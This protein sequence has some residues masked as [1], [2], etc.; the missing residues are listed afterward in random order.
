MLRSNKWN[1]SVIGVLITGAV[2]VVL[3]LIFI[4][5]FFQ[6]VQPS[7]KGIVISWGQLQENV[8]DDGFYFKKPFW[9]DIVP[10][11]IGQNSTDDSK[12]VNAFRGIEPLSKDWQKMDIDAQIEYSITNPILFRRAT[13]MTEP[14]IIETLVLIPQVRRLLYDYTA[15]YTWKSLI[16]WGERQELG[17]RI[18]NTL[19]TGEVTKRICKDEK[20]TTD[21][22]TWIETIELA[23]CEI[24][25]NGKIEASTIKWVAI[26]S[27]NLRK[28]KPNDKIIQAVENAQ[29]KEQEVLVAKQEAQIETEKANKVIETKRGQT[30]SAKLQAEVDAYKIRVALE[31]KAEG[32]KAEALALIEQAKAQK[33]LKEALAGSKDLIEYKR[34]EVEMKLAEAQI[35]YAK[36]Y[37]GAVPNSISVIWTEEAKW[38]SIVMWA[39][40]VPTVSVK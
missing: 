13:W 15:E 4:S 2:L 31:E 11:F 5:E 22:T 23:G 10:V 21:E 27:V 16:Q 26:T 28:V 34:I 37:K 40:V 17:Q 12:N 7:Y 38:M 36:N 6:T 30:E 20:I 3:W 35:E 19:T 18:Y 8:L 25:D 29:L 1:A 39:G 9:T 24:V 33:A 32:I 14:R